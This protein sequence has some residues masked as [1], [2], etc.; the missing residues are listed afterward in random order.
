VALGGR[1]SSSSSSGDGSVSGRSWQDRRGAEVEGMEAAEE[2][3]DRSDRQTV[4]CQALVQ[5]LFV[6]RTPRV[7][8]C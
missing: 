1:G 2:D 6:L 3:L 7:V 5:T 8:V 4:D